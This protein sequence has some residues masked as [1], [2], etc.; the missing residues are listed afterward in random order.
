MIVSAWSAWSLVITRKSSMT[1]DDRA[2]MTL[3]DVADYCRAFVATVRYW[4]ARG[5]LRSLH[6]GRR[7]LVRREDLLRFLDSER[8]STVTPISISHDRAKWDAW[9]K[10]ATAVRAALVA[11]FAR[12][13]RAPWPSARCTDSHCLHKRRAVWSPATCLAGTRRRL[14]TVQTSRRPEPVSPTMLGQGTEPVR[15]PRRDAP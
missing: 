1:D 9:P 15:T 4:I 3:D 11:E 13:R 8:A 2:L 7:Q 10:R 12:S 14:A 5:R 6:P